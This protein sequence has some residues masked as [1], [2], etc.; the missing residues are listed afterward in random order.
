MSHFSH[1]DSIVQERETGKVIGK[2]TR[3]NQL[4]P[5]QITAPPRDKYL[6]AVFCGGSNN[7]CQLWHKHLGHPNAQKL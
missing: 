6:F 2:G 5:L 3:R 7:E 1:S 4:F